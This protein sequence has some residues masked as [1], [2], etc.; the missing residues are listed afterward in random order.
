MPATVQYSLTIAASCLSLSRATNAFMRSSSRAFDA[1][2]ERSPTPIRLRR[3]LR[4]CSASAALSVTVRRRFP[5]FDPLHRDGVCLVQQR[6]DS[7]RGSL[8]K[9]DQFLDPVSD[10]GPK[11]GAP[12][13]RPRANSRVVQTHCDEGGDAPL[14]LLAVLHPVAD[15]VPEERGYV[16]LAI[17]EIRLW[18]DG[19]E[20]IPLAKDV[21]VVEVAVHEPIGAWVELREQLAGE[22]NQ[23]AALVLRVV[24]P[25]PNLRHN[26]PERRSRMAPKL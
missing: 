18:I 19:D 11:I 14:D 10:F 24:E 16:V 12:D 6:L 20:P 15:R 8:S 7:P 9:L 2:N 22:G 17:G 13:H 3:G 4:L 23:L 5:S 25:S 21:V 26:Q 1:T